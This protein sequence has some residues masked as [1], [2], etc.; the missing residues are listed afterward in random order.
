MFQAIMYHYIRPF[1]E[2]LPFFKNLH[3]DDFAKQLDFFER[4]YGFVSKEDFLDSFETGVVPKGVLLTF[5]DGLKCHYEYAFKELKKRNLWGIFYIPT[6]PYQ[7]NKL[8]DVHRIHLLLGMY[9]G[10]EVYVELMELVTN[11][12]LN[13]DLVAEFQELTYHLQEN[14]DSTQWVKRILNYYID[15]QFREKVIDQLMRNL[16]PEELYSI[17]NFY[18]TVEEINEM[19]NNNMIIGS[20]TV[21]HPVMSKLN[22][23]EQHDEINRSF[24]FLNS[25]TNNLEIKTFCYPYG[26]F[27]TFTTESEK[28]LDQA[29]CLFSFNVE[30]RDISIDDII[31]RPQAL[32]RYDCNVFLHGKCR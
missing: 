23:D 9:S 1:N 6:A 22:L 18:L 12:M 19:S 16:I 7:T 13:H 25:V 14:D 29:N 5:D 11:E 8:L 28:L 27:H 26:G 3:A 32:P 31:N 30:H 21:T 20:H 24:D 15:Y 17:E 2:E 4:E 10:N